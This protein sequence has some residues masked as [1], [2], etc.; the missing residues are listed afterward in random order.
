VIKKENKVYRALSFIDNWFIFFL[1][2]PL[3]VVLTVGACT[4]KPEA[5]AN[6]EQM[7]YVKATYVYIYCINGHEFI[8]GPRGFVQHFTVNGA[9]Y[10]TPV[11]CSCTAKAEAEP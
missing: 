5:V 2:I 10:L 7:C 11:V 6:T 4:P 9:G 3:L 8:S 1:C